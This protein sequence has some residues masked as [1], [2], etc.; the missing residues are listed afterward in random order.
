MINLGI[1]VA[2]VRGVLDQHTVVRR[3]SPN[4]DPIGSAGAPPDPSLPP[5][6]AGADSVENIAVVLKRVEA[7]PFSARL[8]IGGG[9]QRRDFARLDELRRPGIYGLVSAKTI[10][11]GTGGDVGA[12]VA[13]GQQPIEELETIFAL[14]DAK[15]ALSVDDARAAERMFWSR[16]AAFGDRRLVNGVPDGASLDP[17]RYG[18]IDLFLAE[19]CHALRQQGLL[20]TRGSARGLVAGPRGEPGRVGALRP[21]NDIPDGE[22]LELS[23]GNGL[24]ALAAR[25][26]DRWLLLRGSDVR[27]DVVS[28]VGASAGFQRAA[29]LHAGLLDFARDGKSYIVTRDLTFRTGSSVAQFCTGAKGRGLA[30]WQPIDPDGGYDPHTAALIAS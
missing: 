21:L 26:S 4:P 5:M 30:G 20:F 29:W 24:I 9:D 18:Q 17:E 12:R 16:V 28:S 22:I 27:I 7:M 1:L 6:V 15:D 23:F 19:A 3:A 10:Y 2:D 13:T 11:V 14:T 8:T 25:Q